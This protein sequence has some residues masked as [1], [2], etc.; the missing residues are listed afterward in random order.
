MSSNY[1]TGQWVGTIVGAVVGFYTGGAGWVAAGAA[2]GG[3]VGGAIDPP[4]GPKIVGPRLNDLTQQTASYGAAIPRLYGATAVM[5]NIFWIENNALKETTTTEGGGGKGGGSEPETTTYSYSATFALGLCEGPITGIKRIWISGK[6]IYNSGSAD[7]GTL[8]A[9]GAAA[10]RFRVYTGAE[11]QQPD[12]RMQAALGAANTP[13]YRGLAYIVFDDLE[14]ADYGNTLLG[15]QIKVEV[16]GIGAIDAPTVVSR[17]TVA[18]AVSGGV[19]YS[20]TATYLS[21]S[22]ELA[23]YRVDG[24]YSVESNPTDLVRTYPDASGIVT[25]SEG[26]M[27]G[28]HIQGWTDTPGFAFLRPFYSGYWIELV[29]GDFDS[30][31]N[32]E[33][34][35]FTLMSKYYRRDREEIYISVAAVKTTVFDASGTIPQPLLVT[36]PASTY[37]IV[38]DIFIG[39]SV[40]YSINIGTSNQF[41]VCYDRDWAVQWTVSI[42]LDVCPMENNIGGNVAKIRERINGHCVVKANELFLEVTQSGYVVLPSTTGGTFTGYGDFGGQHL[43]GNLWITYIA[44]S[45]EISVVNLYPLSA[46]LPT[47][48]SIITA[49][50][51]ATNILT[52][53]DIDVTTLT[54]EVRGYKISSVAAIRSSLDPLQG[55]WP[56]D[57]VQSG[58]K[59]SF[60][61]RGGSVVATIPASDL[62]AGAEGEAL[63]ARFTESR[64]MA[65][66]LPARVTIRHMDISREYD[67]GEQYAERLNTGSVDVRSI[68]MP[69]V[70]TAQEAV[71]KAEILIY[72]YW[73]ERYDVSFTLPPT[74]AGLEPADVVTIEAESGTYELR[75]TSVNYQSNG[76]IECTG[77]FNRAAVYASAATTD[78]GTIPDGIITLPVPSGY[79]L[80]DIPLLDDDYD[81]GGFT[82]AM[83]GLTAGWKGGSIFRSSDGQTWRLINGFRIQSVIGRAINSIG[84]PLEH[85]L[86]D[87]ASILNVSLLGGEAL[88][89]VTEPQMLNGANHFAY[90]VDGRWEIIAAQN[91]ELQID[92]TYLLTD[93]LRGRAGSEWAMGLHEIGDT[94]VL[95]D[96]ARLQFSSA[97]LNQIGLTLDYRGVTA[98][99]TIA[100]DR[101]H[102]FTYR[103][104]NLECLAPVYLNG[105][106]DPATNDWSLEWVRRTRVGGEW[107]DYVDAT[108]GE[109]AESYEIDIMDGAAVKRTLTASTPA[110]A[111]TSAQQVTDFGSD[112]ATLSLN[113]YQ[114]SSTVGRGYPLAATITR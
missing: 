33:A 89:S 7:S 55:A 22:G 106:R 65:T 69:I 102:P 41:F 112:Q 2:L 43:L 67:I 84:A 97:N 46:S 20:S 3:A 86:I 58:Y 51:L 49:E 34:T 72:M 44:N 79:A 18:G 21:P 19:A 5:G 62:G 16:V 60:K 88:S 40:N 94:V 66:Q 92:G 68:E 82:V 26:N 53:P 36:T 31:H 104:V 103:A 52:A 13:A 39:E 38:H 54:D 109:T 70:L 61:R 108:L 85:R 28:M 42:P 98:G 30:L 17:N 78:G 57:V 101:S 32:F 71:Q 90:G 29:E 50:C 15:A 77:K 45:N 11:D 63:P 93:L 47:L 9:S 25:K 35:D 107:R 4:K 111:Y 91:C 83:C 81:T 1:T 56:F 8:V 23:I 110:V 37:G 12:P 113:I 75:L 10:D 24:D 96:A 114:L 59:I 6:L 74:Y 48:A 76:I 87:K 100:S 99:Q 73:L 80:L 64:D 14:L 95:M 105:N 27:A